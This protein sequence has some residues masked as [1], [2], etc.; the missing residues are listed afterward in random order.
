MRTVPPAST[1]KLEVDR[2]KHPLGQLFVGDAL[3]EQPGNELFRQPGGAEPDTGL[4]TH[5][6]R[7]KF[8][9]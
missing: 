8:R 1:S 2:V 6:L 9:S 3:A 4:D 7:G 5:V